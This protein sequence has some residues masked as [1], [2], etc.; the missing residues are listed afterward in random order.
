MLNGGH[1]PGDAEYYD[2][3]FSGL[4]TSVLTRVRELEKTGAL[5]AETPNIAASFQRSVT[6]VLVGKTVR[7]VG[8]K[9]CRRVVLGGRVSGGGKGLP[10]GRLDVDEGS[11]GLARAGQ[12]RGARGG[13]LEVVARLGADGDQRH[14]AGQDRVEFLFRG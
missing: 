10:Y 6:E 1:E 2:F 7:A 4:K 5:E 11:P 8:Q 14:G 3:S 12:L 9:Q 13:V